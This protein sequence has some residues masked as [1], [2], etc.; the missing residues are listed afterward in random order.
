[1]AFVGRIAW[2][3]APH[4][5]DRPPVAELG[6]NPGLEPENVAEA[7]AV[8]ALVEGCEVGVRDVERRWF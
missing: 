7:V 5:G 4:V 3:L 8:C 1:M 2:G 6:G